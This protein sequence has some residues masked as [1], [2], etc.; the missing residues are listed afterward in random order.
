MKGE[1][2][3]GF[4]SDF[5]VDRTQYDLKTYPGAIGND[6]NITVALEAIAQ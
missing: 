2:R 6:V 4:L 5:T 3:L 1:T